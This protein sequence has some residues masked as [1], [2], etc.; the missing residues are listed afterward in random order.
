MLGTE[1]G[2]IQLEID[3]GA[4]AIDTRPSHRLFTDA[5]EPE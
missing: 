5:H 2:G 3:S 1:I 4:P